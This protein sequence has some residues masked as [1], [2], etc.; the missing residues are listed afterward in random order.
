MRYLYILIL[1]AAVI[2]FGHSCDQ[3]EICQNASESYANAHF[4]KQE[5]N[6][7]QDTSFGRLTIR[8]IQIPDTIPFDT[9][10]NQKS[11]QLPLPQGSDSCTFVLSFAVY[12]SVIIEVNDS[13]QELIW[14]ITHYVDDT[15]RLR[16][17]RQMYL[18]SVDC[19]FTHL[20]DLKDVFHTNHMIKS[21]EILNSET[22]TSNEEN[23]R[24]LF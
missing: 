3:G 5:N 11:I 12:D 18:E 20:F 8:G 2:V 15:L 7:L 13:V 6:V 24:I 19:G 23:I 14:D 9:L 21:A 17:S 10:L 4:Y 16:F 1:F 22:G